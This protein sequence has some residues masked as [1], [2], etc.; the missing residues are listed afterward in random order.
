MM[1]QADSF[2]P[3]TLMGKRQ[4]I[5][6]LVKVVLVILKRITNT[7]SELGILDQINT[8]MEWHFYLT[9]TVM[10]VGQQKANNNPPLTVWVDT[11]SL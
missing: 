1:V 10:K 4:P 9:A 11:T 5:L 2:K 3:S 8:E 7:V 6:E